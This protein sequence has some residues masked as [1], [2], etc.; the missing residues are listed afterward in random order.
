V[1]AE[2]GAVATDGAADDVPDRRHRCIRD[3]FSDDLFASPENVG[4]TGLGMGLWWPANQMT[5]NP[6][7]A[8]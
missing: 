6:I 7:A 3:G 1:F 4:P 8:D 2:G 5:G